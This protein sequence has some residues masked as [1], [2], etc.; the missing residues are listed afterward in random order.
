MGRFE[1]KNDDK[2]LIQEGLKQLFSQ[3]ESHCTNLRSVVEY[4]KHIS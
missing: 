4:R 1:G 3:E 2:K